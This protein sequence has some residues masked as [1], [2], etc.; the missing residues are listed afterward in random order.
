MRRPAFLLML[1]LLVAMVAGCGPLAGGHGNLANTWTPPPAATAFRPGVG[2][3][4]DDVSDTASRADYAPFDCADRH[5][6]ETYYVGDLP[7]AGNDAAALRTAYAECSD[8]AVAFAGGV[9]RSGRLAVRPVLPGPAEWAAGSRWFRCDL[10]EVDVGTGA[11]V[12]RTGTL[13]GSFEALRLRCF[14]AQLAGDTVRA[15]TPVSCDRGH[16]AEFAGRWQAPAAGPVI[17]DDDPRLARGCRRTIAAFAGL[18]DDA[19]LQYRV[20]W[21]AFAPDTTWDLGERAVQC[22]LWRDGATMRGSYAGAGPGKL[23]VTSG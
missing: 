18:P 6:A 17:A 12:G 10:S 5:V 4:F 14:D 8:R 9:P 22:F 23:P 15:M 3:C 21:L 20:G 1:L 19:D 13:R 11:P 2:V 16:D 7:G